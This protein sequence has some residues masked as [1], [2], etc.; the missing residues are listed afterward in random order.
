MCS[1]D[2]IELFLA[3]TH[4]LATTAAI[5]RQLGTHHP[6]P[7][8]VIRDELIRLRTIVVDGVDEAN[9]VLE[10]AVQTAEATLDTL[11]AEFNTLS[12]EHRAAVAR[13]ETLES[14]L[15]DREADLANCQDELACA[16]EEIE[17]RTHSDHL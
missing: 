8:R 6:A 16:V 12:E 10:A 4:T 9:Q 11:Q 13:I 17:T 3:G 5:N 7:E 2:L 14:E 1:S 15:A